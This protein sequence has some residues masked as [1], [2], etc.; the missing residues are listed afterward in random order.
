[1]PH[2]LLDNLEPDARRTQMSYPELP[3]NLLELED[4]MLET[5]RRE[6]LFRQTLAANADG[7]PFVF[8]EG[9]PTANGKPGLHHIISRTL[10][11]LVCRH[12][13]MKG[14]SVTRIA[15]WDTHGLPVEI[16]AERKL[17]ISG[18]PEIEKLGIARF[19]EVCKASV[20]TYKE[21]WEKL[22]E[23]IGYWLDYSRP[24]VTFHAEYIESVWWILKEL[25]RKGLLYRGYKS[26]PYCPRCGTALS[27]HEVA[28]G[29]R[30]IEDASLYFLCP[31]VGEH[32]EADP[33]GRAFLVWTTT[34]WTVPSNVGL[35]V[36]PHLTYVEVKA[37]ARRVILAEAR[38]E[39]VLGE[40]AEILRRYS[41]SELEGQPYRRPLDLVPV[42]AETGKSWSVVLEDFVSAEEGTGIVHM[43]P[44]FGSDDYAAGQ[45][46]DLIM[47]RPV[48]DAGRFGEEIPVVGGMFVKDADPLLVE[49]LKKAGTLYHHGTQVHSYPHCW[50]CDSPLIY[51]ARDS[52]F[53]ATS[54][55]K[56]EML[57]ENRKIGWLPPEVGE[58]RF[59]EWLENNV[60][61]ALSRDRYWGTPLPA[62]VCDQDP[63]H[64]DWIGGLEELAKTAGGLPEGFDPHRPFIDEVT[65][66]CRR[67]DGTM[68]RT[69]GVVDVWFDSGAMPFAQWHY[70]FE[71]QEEFE[72]HFPADFIC[73]ALDQTRGWFYSLLAI[74]TMLGRGSSYRNVMV[75][76]LILDE[77]G[78]KMSKSRGNVVD[79]WDA[80][81][82]HGADAVRWYLVTVSQPGASKRFDAE[83]VRE[84]SRKYFDTLFNTY[85][86]FSQYARAE[87]WRPSDDDPAPQ[88]RPLIDRWILSRLNSL[89]SVVESELE[90]FQVTRAFRSAGDFLNDDLSNWYVRRSR[91]RFW[92]N[93]DTL[94]ARAA[95]RTLW[96]VLL[97]MA[98][99]VAPITPFSADWIHR[100]LDGGSVHL[101]RFPSAEPL[102]M[103]EALEEGMEGLRALV[104]LGRA[105]REAVQIKVRQ[106][107]GRMFA[108]T[109]GELSLDGEL[110][111][112]LKD[113]LNVKKVSFLGSSEELVSLAA[114]PN[115]RVLGP[116]FQHLTEAAA[117][118]I[119]ALDP[120]TLAAY[121]EGERVEIQV[122]DSRFV[123]NPEELDVV[124]EARGDLVVQGDGR[125]TAALDPS[126][127]PELR[128]EGM[129]RELVNRI[130]RLRKDAGLE[131]T[132]RI[133]LGIM[134]PGEVRE[135]ADSFREFIAG[136]TLA[137]GFEVE[138]GEGS[139]SGFDAHREV[140][141]DGVLAHI[142]LSRV[143]R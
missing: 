103:D 105:A 123:L 18:K 128:S 35:A 136:E 2:T 93:A 127:S 118:A 40:G 75:N 10:K 96:E 99:L 135:A 4:E 44:A 20:F 76:G 14:H 3:K 9:P 30:E 52:W 64:V 115:Y 114:K 102:L 101:S 66:A 132:D 63:E 85:R 81:K 56:D 86:F 24:Y 51:M 100:A 43:A 59:G 104:S 32:G 38:A 130:Q 73:E 70:P 49:E 95:F 119:R 46:H 77:E 29:Y 79:P 7:Q 106:P 39:E 89:V 82:E 47:L 74:S 33:D 71:N 45:R 108:V 109:P 11:D 58:K 84:S 23:R 55:L 28:Q 5:W 31:L 124:E 60:D 80:V 72:R 6:D 65:W 134:G 17:G 61:W 26:V 41:A 8:Y 97:T 111:G 116:R 21:D 62:W 12:R 13:A 125:F 120:P 110:L 50:R 69:P 54:T 67:C 142:A 16:E 34:P 137:V 91:A 112:L 19:N 138:S 88:D 90:A 42:P 131:I 117:G 37:G 133:S 107:L 48:D 25:A 126:I 1:M 129:A 94:D 83:G 140:D 122:G 15:G 22:S 141:L 68:R 139:L 27:S 57:E 36:H 113:E 78:L 53:A 87:D 121:R 98:R 92:G 143:A